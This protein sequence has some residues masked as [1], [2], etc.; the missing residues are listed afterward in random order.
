MK[1]FIKNYI[2]LKLYLL[3]FENYKL[4]LYHLILIVEQMNSDY[5]SNLFIQEYYSALQKNRPALIKFYT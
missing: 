4:G 1:L 3:I 5:I 2:I